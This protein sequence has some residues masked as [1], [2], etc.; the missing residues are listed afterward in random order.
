MT[1]VASGP[2]TMAREMRA[3][4]MNS[5]P[6]A[7][8]AYSAAL[9]SLALTGQTAQPA[10]VAERSRAA[11]A[12]DQAIRGG[13]TTPWRVI[14]QNALAGAPIHAPLSVSPPPR[15]LA[16]TDRGLS[17]PSPHRLNM[18]VNSVAS[19]DVTLQVPTT[20]A[21]HMV[22]SASWQSEI[23]NGPVPAASAAR[24]GSQAKVNQPALRR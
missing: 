1:A 12:A 20:H 3:S 10:A 16:Q 19:E 15:Q 7:A 8:S 5:L 11:H 6:R 21:K 17:V 24:S 22:T 13:T 18:S 23:A 14:G 4:M 2:A 9:H